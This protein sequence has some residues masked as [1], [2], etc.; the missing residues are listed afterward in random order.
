MVKKLLSDLKEVLTWLLIYSRKPGSILSLNKDTKTK[1]TNY[2][3]PCIMA[4]HPG[5]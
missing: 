5:Y 2:K 3:F 1:E 4:T